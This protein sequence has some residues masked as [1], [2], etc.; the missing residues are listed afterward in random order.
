MKELELKLIIDETTASEV[1]KR[2]LAAKLSKTRP[3]ARRIKTTYVDT[4]DHRLRDA[5]ISLRLRRDG[6]RYLQT[7]KSKA[8]LHGGLSDVVEMETTLPKDQ[9][10]LTS[11]PDKRLRNEIV[12]LVNGAALKAAC[13]TLVKRAE[14]E[15]S[16]RHGTRA[17]LAVDVAEI[18]AGKQSDTFYELELEHVDGSPAGLFDIAKE[19]LPEGGATFSPLSKAERG[20]LLA[21]TGKVKPEPK[22]CKAEV[23]VLSKHQTK[24]QAAQEVLR[25]IAAQI[26]ANV[27][28]VLQLSV[29]EGPH[30]LRIGLRRLR[31]ALLIFREVIGNPAAKHIASEAKWLGH[32]VG[33]LR[34]LDVIINDIV[35]REAE[36]HPELGG[37]DRLAKALGK[38]ADAVRLELRNLLIGHRVQS[39][40]FD[41]MKF[42]ETRGWIN[43]VEI[44]QTARLAA[45]VIE[46]AGPA[47]N[48]RW[49][50]VSRC[51]KHIQDISVEDRHILRKELK[52]LRYAVEFLA[53]LYP[54]KKVKP[55]LKNLRKLQDVFGDLNDAAMIKAA[56]IEGDLLAD[57]DNIHMLVGWVA[58]A[59][60]AR[61]DLHWE[62]AQR[63]WKDL[64]HTPL[65]WR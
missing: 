51:A 43:V 18:N 4:P 36:A 1:W 34:D 13:T 26:A 47:L 30:Q 5:C 61:A 7:V 2:A 31:S 59:S 49:K 33:R 52:K 48:K 11:I 55:F 63:L 65:F 25:E 32:Q 45:P 23:V 54:A 12:S 46:L 44:E 15:V 60:S 3:K 41:L 21:K 6:R 50:K 14:A 20:F 16:H 56:L 38:Q 53:P 8:S 24:E 27:T 62:H 22:P 17:M 29:P 40:L 42:I 57:N 28:A 9:L 39:F 10:D 64:T 35:L 37:F 19:L 58:G